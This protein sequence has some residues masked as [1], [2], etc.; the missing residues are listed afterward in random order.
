VRTDQ[1][2]VTFYGWG[3]KEDMAQSICG[4]TRGWQVKLCDLSLTRAIP[5]RLR[6]ELVSISC[7][8]NVLFTVH[9]FNTT[10]ALVNCHV[11]GEPGSAGCLP[12]SA[13][14]CL[15]QPLFAWVS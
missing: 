10:R 6:D 3:V 13:A 4:Y 5:E 12:G 2:V 8:T 11:T 9:T 1:S 15:G 14:V 7:Y